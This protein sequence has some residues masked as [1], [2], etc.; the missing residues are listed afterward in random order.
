M[1]APTARAT[2]VTD[3]TATSEFIDL[4]A[5]VDPQQFGLVDIYARS[6]H[7]TLI[8]N[9]LEQAIATCMTALGHDY[10][11]TRREPGNDPYVLDS[12]LGLTDEHRAAATGYLAPP[13]PMLDEASRE[14]ARHTGDDNYLAALFGD[15]EP[16][17]VDVTSPITGEVVTSLEVRSGCVGEADRAVFGSDEARVQ[18]VALDRVLQEAVIAS[19]NAALA[20]SP[21]QVANAAWADCMAARGFVYSDPIAVTETQWPEPRPSPDETRVAVAD[22]S[23]KAEV[24]LVPIYRGQLQS[25]T[26]LKEV[27][28]A[29]LI[30]QWRDLTAAI[31]T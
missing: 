21:V 29:G 19:I 1:T 8:A 14:V 20:S 16:T 15:D 23:C 6:D 30:D 2:T 18:F 31:V 24:Q 12:P 10:V 11:P 5:R 22:T 28:L 13:D 7:R 9:Q 26:Q 17:R 25:I 4:S 27:D 3:P